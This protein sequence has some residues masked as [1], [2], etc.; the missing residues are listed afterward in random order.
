M[1]ASIYFVSIEE[2]YNEKIESISIREKNKLTVSW[3]K[4]G[5]ARSRVEFVTCWIYWQYSKQDWA[6][7][8]QTQ[9]NLI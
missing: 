1:I 6:E 4:L 8:S 2:V 9:S 5:K 7:L 3:A